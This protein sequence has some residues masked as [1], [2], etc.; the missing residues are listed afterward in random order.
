MID[1][2]TARQTAYA[3]HGGGGSPLYAFAS[4]SGSGA[5][6]NVTPATLGEVDSCLAWTNT[7]APD[8]LISLDELSD[9]REF[10]VANLPAE[11]S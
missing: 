9:L 8:C 4:M 5:I 3:W 1:L 7:H 2:E 11:I 6:Q 10:L